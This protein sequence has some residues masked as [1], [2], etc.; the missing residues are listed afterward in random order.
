LQ[1]LLK[2]ELTKV[3]MTVT[4]KFFI[5]IIQRIGLSFFK[6]KVAKW[7]YERGSRVLIDNLKSS[8]TN[9][10]QNGA[11]VA[12]ELIDDSE[13]DCVPAEIED[14]IEQ[15]LFGLKDSNTYVRWSSAKG[16]G[17][18]CNRL[19]KDM[20][21]D[22][23]SSIL[24]LFTFE[25]DDNAWHGGCLAIA[26]LG[27]RGLLLPK[28]LNLVIPII[29]KALV[30]DK[31][32]GNYSLGRNVRD[33]ACY[34]C[35]S[36]ARAFEPTIIQSH[37]NDIA[38]TLLITTVFDREVN[39][40]RAASAAFQENVGRQG[41][42]PHGIDILTKADYF[43]VGQRPNCYL[44][45]SVFIASYT[46]YTQPLITHLLEY[47]FNHWDAEIRELTAK[48]LFNLTSICPDYMSQNI[49]SFMIKQCLHFDL[50]TRH[51]ALLSIS[52]IIHALC[53]YSIET[54][55]DKCEF[56]TNDLLNDLKQIIPKLQEAKY[57][58]GLG[59][60]ILRPAC[61][62]FI[63]KLSVSKLYEQLDENFLQTCEE[64]LL[65]CIEYNKE[66]VQL[67]AFDALPY[68]CDF[69]SSDKELYNKI[70]LSL[71]DRFL[72]NMST[73]KEYVR[74]GYLMALGSLPLH[75][76]QESTEKV[77]KELINAIQIHSNTQ[78][79]VQSRKDA[80]KAILK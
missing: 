42:F 56:F 77:I 38:S 28:Q 10:I 40:R 32:L 16:I 31:K 11:K 49:L 61:C 46:E 71:I 20:A 79:W 21:E 4:R 72:S 62:L 44:N 52:Q 47:K 6:E 65:E 22:I 19:S 29:L 36:L 39:C 73:P 18:I 76:I 17:R 15:L 27:R 67:A 30:F 43:A 63:Q 50:N 80:I 69:Y 75:M 55:K 33:S 64:F 78:L 3:E 51:G 45:L 68:Y 9:G 57:L 66:D 53:V 8:Q 60:E 26:E 7:R 2:H 70:K 5:K 74:S 48:A 59:G 35:W 41:Q 1:H 14:I 25:E 23:L 34:V 37:V 54:K 13:E 12:T 24:E 58:K